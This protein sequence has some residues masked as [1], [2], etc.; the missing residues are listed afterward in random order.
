MSLAHRSVFPLSAAWS[1]TPLAKIAASRRGSRRAADRSKSRRRVTWWFSL[2]NRA[3]TCEAWQSPTRGAHQIDGAIPFS[4]Y[5]FTPPF[6]LHREGSGVTQAIVEQ[7]GQAMPMQHRRKGTAAV[8]F[9]LVAPVFTLIIFGAVKWAGHSRCNRPSTTPFV[10]AAGG[11][12]KER[13]RFPWLAD[14]HGGLCTVF[15]YRFAEQCKPGHQYRQRDRNC[16]LKRSYHFRSQPDASHGHGN[17][18][19]LQGGLLDAFSHQTICPQRS[20]C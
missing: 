17:R 15:G 20:R 16:R 6:L 2:S 3:A 19:V 4:S 13:P 12:P 5:R 8:E 9:A 7:G 1:S 14:G 18:A 10:K 11:S